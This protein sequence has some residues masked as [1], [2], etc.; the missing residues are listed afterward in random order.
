MLDNDYPLDL[1]AIL[2]GIGETEVMSIFF[3]ILGKALVIDF[4]YTDEIPPM[5]RV[6]DQVQNAQERMRSLRRLRPQFPRPEK[7]ALLPWM[8]SAQMM[9]ETGVWAAVVQRV[10]SPG[11]P[12]AV[13]ASRKAFARLEGL[14]GEAY[15]KA[16]LGIDFRTIWEKAKA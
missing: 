15:R 2:D 3:P 7:F 16:I 1:P 11:F 12:Q 8:K 5:V 13:E 9:K 10:A 14:E 4:R 6:M